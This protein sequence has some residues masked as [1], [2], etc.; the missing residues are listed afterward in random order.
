MT[1][2][3]DEVEG[4]WGLELVEWQT[5][6]LARWYLAKRLGEPHFIHFGT[7]RARAYIASFRAGV[8]RE[9]AYQWF[10][11]GTPAALPRPGAE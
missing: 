1:G 2:R 8:F 9:H 5:Q 7:P 4:P 3:G 10:V 6:L 11:R